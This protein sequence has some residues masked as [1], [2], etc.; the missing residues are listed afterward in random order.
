MR[1]SLDQAK[2]GKKRFDEEGDTFTRSKMATKA[3]PDQV[4]IV[5]RI[6]SSEEKALALPGVRDALAAA[7]VANVNS[8]SA[9]S[10]AELQRYNRVVGRFQRPVEFFRTD[11][12][13]FVDWTLIRVRHV[14]DGECP[15][16]L[17]AESK[18]SP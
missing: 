14:L 11:N 13:L 3:V 15:T 12:V 17:L 8:T 2:R 7:P 18:P 5:R 10:A 4:E 1:E 6:S 9:T 16:C